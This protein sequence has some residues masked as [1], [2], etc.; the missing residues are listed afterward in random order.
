MLHLLFGMPTTDENKDC[1]DLTTLG[2]VRRQ[3]RSLSKKGSNDRQDAHIKSNQIWTAYL[4]VMF[5]GCMQ[6]L[7]EIM[8]I[9]RDLIS[10]GF[11]TKKKDLRRLIYDIRD[12]FDC[13]EFE[14]CQNKNKW[15]RKTNW[16]R[17]TSIFQCVIRICRSHVQIIFTLSSLFWR[18]LN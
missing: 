3:Q 17:I 16:N 11:E 15:I 9:W 2:S 8:R 13:M 7:R 10:I 6:S 18:M 1:W 14:I 5:I 4:Y 12:R